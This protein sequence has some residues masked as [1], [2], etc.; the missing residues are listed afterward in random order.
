MAT[1]QLKNKLKNEA[2]KLGINLIGFANVKRW[3]DSVE[4]NRAFWPQTI[5]PW[6]KVVIVL[7]V[8]IYLPMLETSPSA[9]YS[10]LYNTT[11]R[12]L[13]ETAYKMANILNTLGHRAFFFPRDCYGDISVLLE[14]PEVA[15][16]HV[17]AGMYAGLGTIGF[18]HTLITKKYGSRVRLVSVITDADITPDTMLSKGLCIN[19]R[20]CLKACP[21][22]A[23]SPNENGRIAHMDK[24][25]CATY[26]QQLKN[27][28]CYPCGICTTACPV[29]ED[30]KLYDKSSVSEEGILHC[31]SFG[32]HRKTTLVD[33][34]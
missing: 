1:L 33:S 22:K 31:Q 17:V 30:R 9:L 20:Q 16:S 12:M 4:I 8:Q 5:W 28:L 34:K 32:S 14:K 24:L 15:F 10:E 23:F 2:K 7:G 27:E 3:E 19:C 6:S 13:D 26:H 21:Q 18:N 29:G 11:N 25:K